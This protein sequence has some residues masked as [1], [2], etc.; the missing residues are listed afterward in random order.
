MRKIAFPLDGV[1]I[2]APEPGDVPTPAT[3]PLQPASRKTAAT[4]LAFTYR[5]CFKTFVLI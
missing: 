4:A 1:A 3:L 2:G 5:I